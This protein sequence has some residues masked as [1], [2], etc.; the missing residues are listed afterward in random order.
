MV[1][2]KYKVATILIITNK[3]ER[4]KKMSLSLRNKKI[5][6]LLHD[7]WRKR[8]CSLPTCPVIVT[9]GCEA[10]HSQWTVSCLN[11]QPCPPWSL[12]NLKTQ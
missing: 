6:K 12:P 1:E 2:V 5:K 4:V 8:C 10:T 11:K 7:T 9:L 3:K